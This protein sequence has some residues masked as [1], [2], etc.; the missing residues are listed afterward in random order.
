MQGDPRVMKLLPAGQPGGRHHCRTGPAK[1]LD[2]GNHVYLSPAGPVFPV[3]I[4]R[5]LYCVN[6]SA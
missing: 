4:I 5:R 1:H 6:W 3:Y 2:R